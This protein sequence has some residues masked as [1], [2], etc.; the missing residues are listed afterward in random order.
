MR[1]IEIF[2]VLSLLF[3]ASREISPYKEQQMIF[4]QSPASLIGESDD[5]SQIL[6]P[7]TFYPISIGSI[8]NN[9]TICQINLTNIQI[10]SKEYDQDMQTNG[11]IT[12]LEDGYKI[13][14]KAGRIAMKISLN[15][16]KRFWGYGG[17]T[18]GMVSWIF[19]INNLSFWKA[20]KYSQGL[21]KSS[22]LDMNISFII[23]DNE[24]YPYDENLKKTLY[25]LLF[26]TQ[27]LSDIQYKIKNSFINLLSQKYLKEY[28]LQSTTYY[29]KYGKNQEV[30]YKQAKKIPFL[31]NEM[32][33]S[34]FDYSIYGYIGEYQEF[35]EAINPIYGEKQ[36]LVSNSLFKNTLFYGFR[37]G[38]FNFILNSS[39]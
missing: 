19:L 25:S 31:D 34:Y 27:G 1:K 39:L 21:A 7:E 10:F 16:S 28:N 23:Q 6:N 14:F 24:M 9:S 11:E 13:V 15:F 3:F 32:L 33:K 8:T 29:Y 2:I 12:L 38:F 30:V 35:P 18:S 17:Q 4:A 5:F 37:E 36:I 26:T 22:I 20:I